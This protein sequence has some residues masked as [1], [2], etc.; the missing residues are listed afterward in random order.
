[1]VEIL[2]SNSVRFPLIGAFFVYAGLQYG[3]AGW[4]LIWCGASFAC[5]GL[6]YALGRPSL[7]GKSRD[8][9]LALW[10]WLPLGPHLFF[11][12][13]SWHAA[14]FFGK[15][16]CCNEIAPKIWLGRRPYADELPPSIGLVVDLTCEF[17]AAAGVK[18]G[19]TYLSC[20]ILDGSVI[21]HGSFTALVERIAAW[22]DRG[23]YIHCAIGHGR[24]AMV[25]AAVLIRRGLHTSA[26]EAVGAI[27]RT[28]PRVGLSPG[29]ME[30]LSGF[31]RRRHERR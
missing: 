27:R 19:R 8:G 7:F 31:A 17:P 29:Q 13:I 14:R 2:R 30:L 24:S 3:P 12:W 9:R 28:R 26:E 16:D 15:E 6:A 5:V 22:N 25:A 10:V 21:D 20:P 1:M 11:T 18:D 23:I 4:V